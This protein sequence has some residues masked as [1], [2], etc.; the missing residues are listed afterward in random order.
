MGDIFG[1]PL[2]FFHGSTLGQI[3]VWSG[4]VLSLLVT[5]LSWSLQKTMAFEEQEEKGFYENLAAL[6][7]KVQ[8]AKK[9]GHPLTALITGAN[10]GIGFA[11]AK[12]L[13]REGCRVIL[14]CRHAGR[15]TEAVKRIM[16]SVPGADIRLLIIDVS[17]PSSVA[18]AVKQLGSDDSLLG[19]EA[20]HIDLLFL[21]AGVMPV[22]RKR[23]DIATKAFFLGRM[24][25]FFE[26][27]R[28]A[29]DSSHFLQ[30]PQDDPVACGA[31]SLFATHVLGHVLLTE[32]L[33]EGGF[34]KDALGE[35][36]KKKAVAIA[37]ADKE[38][39]SP[40]VNAA[41][42]GDVGFAASSDVPSM[43][44]LGRVIWTSSRAC[45]APHLD[46]DHVAPP[47]SYGEKSP[48]ELNWLA[49]GIPH[50]EAY[51]EAKYC[52]DLMNAAL[53]KRLPYPCLAICPGAV[54]T[55]IMPPFFKPFLG[56]FKAL[57][58]FLPG[59]NI[60]AERGAH[61]LVATSVLPS[62]SLSSERKYATWAG[63]LLPIGEGHGFWPLPEDQQEK[64]YALVSKWLKLWRQH[65]AEASSSKKA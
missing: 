43:S 21:N 1:I 64:M 58:A 63:E 18:K 60:T 3:A 13:S 27:G 35:K 62:K 54:D 47:S 53:S 25:F 46:W 51:G 39:V 57:R 38:N 12:I 34:L 29:P 33:H 48:F 4:V 24:G 19:E 59:F 41:V 16:D 61:A 65:A 6:R 30:Q 45:C 42:D 14:G 17:D 28:C 9:Q 5:V 2:E 26:T 20:K 44:R 36:A 31:P 56:L 22:G 11:L 52:A 50:R 37:T 7:K 32:M 8:T 15:G 10:S 23:W 40:L 55:E 49:K